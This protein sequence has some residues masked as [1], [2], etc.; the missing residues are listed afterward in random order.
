MSPA[1]WQQFCWVLNVFTH[2]PLDKMAAILA[3]DIF[4]FIF[5]HE[6]DRIHIQ[7]SLKF[8]PESPLD[9]KTSFPC[10]NLFALYIF[11]TH[12]RIL[13]LLANVFCLSY[14]FK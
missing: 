14:D 11:C 12:S 8:I 9:N 4:I 10:I 6:N 5:L 13:A 3:D 7:I 1:K 2:L